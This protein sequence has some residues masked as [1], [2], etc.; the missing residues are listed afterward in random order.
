MNMKS[1][2]NRIKTN[3]SETHF[4]SNYQYWEKL[5]FSSFMHYYRKKEYVVHIKYKIISLISYKW[6]LD[7]L[8]PPKKKKKK[9]QKVFSSQHSKRFDGKKKEKNLKKF[10]FFSFWIFINCGYTWF[11]DVKPYQ[12][13]VYVQHAPIIGAI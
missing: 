12:T 7:I 1:I 10:V 8:C 9:N 6:F 13:E 4:K 2:N 5:L 11:R 3:P